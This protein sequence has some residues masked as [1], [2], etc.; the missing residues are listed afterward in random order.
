MLLDARRSVH[1]PRRSTLGARTSTL[2]ALAFR[3]SVHA[4][5]HSTLRR[6]M[7]DTSALDARRVDTSTLDTWCTYL[8]AR[9]FGASML[10]ARTS[11]LKASALDARRVDASTL[12]A[13][14]STLGARTST[15]DASAFRLSVH[16]PRCSTL[17]RSV[18][19]PRRSTLWRFD[20]RCTNLDARCVDALTLGARTLT[21]GARRFGVR[22]THIGAPRF[23]T[24]RQCLRVLDTMSGFHRCVTCQAKL[25]ASDPHEDCV[26]CLGPDHAAS[27]LADRAY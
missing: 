16:T 26:A 25:P 8:D 15:L 14:A 4:P 1:A 18:H 19:T 11:T 3:R 9:R 12:G 7:L 23:A 6:S 13:R 22:R 5:R 17:R 24:A 20:T 2:N 10:G 21:L 27:A